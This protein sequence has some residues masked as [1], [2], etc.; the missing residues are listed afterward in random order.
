MCHFPCRLR[1]QRIQQHVVTLENLLVEIGKV[2][3]V[4]PDHKPA[5]IFFYQA[6]P[7]PVQDPAWR[8]L[9]LE[10]H[11]RQIDAEIR[12]LP[13]HPPEN[14]CVITDYDTT[15]DTGMRPDHTRIRM[16]PDRGFNLA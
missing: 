8:N 12:I 3:S 16:R 5:G 14:L 13:K 7:F 1:L 9:L 11:P 6:H 15:A 4:R 2:A 10:D